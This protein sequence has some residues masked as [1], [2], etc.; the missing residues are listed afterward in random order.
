VTLVLA[1]GN[2]QAKSPPLAVLDG[3]EVIDEKEPNNGFREAQD[4]E[5][6]KVIRGAIQ[7]PGD[8]DV[9]RFTGRAGQKVRI[10]V[11]AARAGS[12]LDSTLCL[13][14]AVGHLVSTND[15]SDL[16]SDSRLAVTLDSDGVYYISIADANDTGSLVHG[17]QLT[18]KAE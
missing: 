16:G 9:Y 4:V 3:S 18:V 10:E 8:V 15:D 2:G 11:L 5:F 6:G 14:D 12:L 7:S 17:Y 1:A 13:Y